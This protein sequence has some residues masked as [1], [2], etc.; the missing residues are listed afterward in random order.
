MARS[1]LNQATD[2]VCLAYELLLD[3]SLEINH[4]VVGEVSPNVTATRLEKERL[5]R[6]IAIAFIRSEIKSF[7]WI[8]KILFYRKYIKLHQLVSIINA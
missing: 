2:R 8:E 4:D 5:S 6:E 3:S 1:L 7:S